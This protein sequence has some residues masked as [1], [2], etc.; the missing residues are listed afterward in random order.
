LS[1]GQLAALALIVVGSGLVI[2][3]WWGR[4]RWLILV[5]FL[6]VPAVMATSYIDM[7]PRGR[8]GS[9]YVTPTSLAEL[10]NDYDLLLGTMTID[11]T[12]VSRA[13]GDASL[14][15]DVA[16]GNV[17][18]YVPERFGLRVNGHIQLGNVTMGRGF[19]E[20]QDLSFARTFEGR[21]GAGTVT[22]D[23]DGGITSL[24]VERISRRERM[25]RPPARGRHR[26][27]G[28]PRDGAERD[29][30]GPRNSKETGPRQERKGGRG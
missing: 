27:E 22:V 8:V 11:L 2:G 24:Y 15:L 18:L 28:P 3:T 14:D 26:Q 9:L 1:I 21:P 20:G 17:T 5:G 29:G 13:G 12:S 10:P 7:P 4:A 25:G 16:A 19:Q 23:V 6:L 30:G